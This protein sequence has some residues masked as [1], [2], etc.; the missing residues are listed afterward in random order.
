LIA[1][2]LFLREIVAFY[3]KEVL[4]KLVKEVKD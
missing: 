4:P 2:K 1:G 3:I